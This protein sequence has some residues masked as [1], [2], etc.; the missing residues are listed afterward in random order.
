MSRGDD[1]LGVGNDPAVVQED[2]DMILRREQ[3][4]DVP[5]THEVG[6]H[7]ALDR[8]LDPRIGG[9]NEVTHP[10]ANLLLPGGQGTDIRVDA[11]VLRVAHCQATT[12]VAIATSFRSQSPAWMKASSP[13]TSCFPRALVERHSVPSRPRAVDR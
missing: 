8:L 4:A 11:R 2:V 6:P 3:R 9:V 12:I 7:F 13:G 1:P 5:F 10:V